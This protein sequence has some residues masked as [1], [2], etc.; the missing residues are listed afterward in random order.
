[1]NTKKSDIF[2]FNSYKSYLILHLGDRRTRSGAKAQFA[3]HLQI[4][5]TYLSKVLFGDADIN[6]EQAERG[7]R[8]FNHSESEAHFFLLLVQKNRAGTPE[9]KKYFEKQITEIKRQQNAL[10]E[11]IGQNVSILKDFEPT[12]YSSWLYSAVHL[13]TTIPRL[14]DPRDIAEALGVPLS[15]TFKITGELLRVGLLEK[16]GTELFPVNAIAHLSADSNFIGVHHQNWRVRAAASLQ[17][18]KQG[19]VHYSGV[20]SLSERAA[21]EIRQL[22]ATHLKKYITLVTEAREEKLFSLAFDFYDL[23]D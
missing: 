8:F 11:Q 19:D 23:E 14:R 6:L 7:N 20:F 18:P 22:L 10:K 3:E 4:Q 16:R 17:Q 15:Q 21:E 13:A 9:L 12:Y 5:S 2:G 1:M